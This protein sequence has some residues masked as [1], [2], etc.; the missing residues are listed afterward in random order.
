MRRMA[1]L[2]WA[3]LLAGVARGAWEP[4]LVDFPSAEDD[5]NRDG[6]PDGWTGSAFRSPAKVAWDESVAHS[7]RRSLRIRD[8]AAEGTEWNQY[9]GRWVTTGRKKVTPGQTYT[10]GAWIK[11]AGV[12]GYA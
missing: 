7:G 3:T 10:L 6:G 1:L 4:N 9:T 5:R 8:S 12:T 11:T 2:L